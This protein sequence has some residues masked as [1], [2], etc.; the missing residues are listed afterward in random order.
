MPLL[1][2]KRDVQDALINHLIA[3][4]WEYL[5][6]DEVLNLR[7]GNLREPFLLPIAKEKLI[8]LNKGVVT[9]A[10]VDDVL[11]WLKSVRPNLEGN[12]EF[13]HY[14]RG[15]KTVYSEKEKRERNLMLIDLDNPKNNH[16]SFAQNTNKIKGFPFEDRDRRE[17]DIVLFI[18]GFPIGI[19]E[20]KSP[21][22]EEAEA[23]AFEQVQQLYT[24]RIPELLKFIQFFA[25]C[26]GLKLH[27]GATWNPDI[28]ALYR[29]KA[30]NGHRLENL[31]KT[32][33]NPEQVLR[34]L[35]D[36]LIFFRTDDQTQK[37]ILRPHQMR[38]VEY[39]VQRVLENIGKTPTTLLDVPKKSGLIWHTQGSGKTL[40][41]I[42]AAHKLCRAESLQNPTI[43]MVV[44]RRE[45]ESQM[46]QNLEA[47]GFP[48]IKKAE[49]RE[50]L[51]QL[52]ASDYRGLI[53]TLIHKFAGIEKDL[54]PRS[55][56]ILLI[57]EA[58]RSQEGELATYMRAALPNAFYFGFTGTPIDRGKIG[59]GTFETF[60]KHDPQGYLDKYGIDESIEDGTTVPLY[61]TLTPS[62]L[63]LD[64]T[65]L[66]NEFFK[67]VE[68]AGVASIEE[69]NKIL[70][71]AEKLKAV[72]KAP[73][74]V[75][76]IAKHIA[77]HYRQYVEPLGFK[78]FVVAVDR[79]ACALYKEALNKH[80][81][82]EYSRV[83]Y[84][85][86]HKDNE[87]L[88]RY[89]ISE[90]EE[91][92]IRRAF[93]TEEL[94]KILI[95]T[96]KL[97]T[98]YDAPVLYCMYLDKPLKDHTLLQAIARVNRPYPTK[99][100][101]LIVDYIGIFENLQRALA[102]DSKDIARGLIDLERL[103]ERFAELMAQAKKMLEPLDL[104]RVEGRTERIVEHFFD[105]ERRN[106]YLRLFK[107][108]QEAYDILSPDP[109][110]RDYIEDYKL[111]IQVYQVIYNFYNPEAEK[112]RVR[113]DILKK[114]DALIR[115]HVELTSLVDTLPIYE[116]NRDIA[117]LIHADRLS[118]RVKLANLHRSIVLHI[119]KH[120][121]TQPYLV[122]IAERVEAIIQALHQRQKSVEAA[123]EEMTR[124]AEAIASSE[125]EQKTLGLGR[126][127]FT[128]FWVLRNHG[129]AEAQLK[130]QAVRKILDQ[131]KEWPYNEQVERALRLALYKQ[132]GSSVSNI[133]ALHAA[134]NSLLKTQRL[135]LT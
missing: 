97:L 102:F 29:W 89:H 83:V 43:L 34:I 129:I 45:L 72:L 3:I 11:K 125:Q 73:D 13:L 33:L 112:K 41:M 111:L 9:A 81:P 94:P 101:G 126:E 105:V 52:L 60:G 79:E 114:T 91:Q 49:S 6:P 127:D 18:N 1:S 107:E 128:V 57:D 56:I 38:T 10:N 95:V 19:I 55:N 77:E 88:R 26:N 15:H 7:G 106:S 109:F 123:L 51:R 48:N 134:V 36:Y 8:A 32:L 50:E 131:Y 58:H 39:I 87:L 21:T 67:L 98:G 122:S 14:L 23:E 40:T 124:L 86:G 2:E 113:R 68:E 71:K 64:K 44:D 120:Q 121:H 110:L 69:L 54:N 12:E 90:D 80:L 133:N 31:A 62:E 100:S 119:E 22:L 104:E 4:G 78:A 66:E 30:K 85:P 84:T 16:Y 47:F 115:E 108:I 17:P 59:K 82:D 116:I 42:I 20:N 24:D 74:R 63:R 93:R 76:N 37:F 53:V 135:M 130:C 35:R 132:L 96:E 117:S 92:R 27:Y 61:Y 25:T 70:E 65:T 103:K 99:K 75:N 5:T 28:K 46:V 118:D